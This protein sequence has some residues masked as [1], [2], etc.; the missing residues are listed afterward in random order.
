MRANIETLLQGGWN[1]VTTLSGAVSDS[2]VVKL[3]WLL[4]KLP[5]AEDYLLTYRSQTLNAA[6]LT[7]EIA[8]ETDADIKTQKTA[9]L[10]RAQ[11][12]AATADAKIEIILYE[13][14]KL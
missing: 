11:K 3:K 4:E 10:R 2:N 14:G 12:Y 9:D 1:Q 8:V 6:R 5:E 7:A 13:Y